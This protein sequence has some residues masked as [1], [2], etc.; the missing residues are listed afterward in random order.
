[1]KVLVTAATR[2]GATGEIAETIGEVLREHGLDSTVG[3]PDD[4]TTVDGYDAVVLGSAV[5]AGRWLKPARELVDRSRDALVARPLWL[6]SSGPVGDPPKPEEDPV[7]VAEIV[8]ATGARDH[9]VFAGKLVRRQLGFADKAIAVA[10]RV[11]DGDFRDWTEIRRWAAGIA[12]AL[13]AGPA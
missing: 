13:R 1:M 5:Y 6:F 3:Q 11:P 8:A 12:E 7:D 9:R 4:V 2:Y 10:L